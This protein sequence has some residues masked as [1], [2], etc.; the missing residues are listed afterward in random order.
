M[1]DPKVAREEHRFGQLL[2]R[3]LVFVEQRVRLGRGY[4]PKLQPVEDE[5]EVIARGKRVAVPNETTKRE[6][7]I[8]VSC[9]P[10][11]SIN[12]C[13]ELIPGMIMIYLYFV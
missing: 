11:F 8:G 2:A 4:T 1:R 7:G 3:S 13:R 9:S 12:I 10:S 6:E 5:A